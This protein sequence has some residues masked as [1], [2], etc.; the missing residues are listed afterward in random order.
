M[1]SVER[2]N[3]KR[4]A[5]AQFRLGNCMLMVSEAGRGFAAMLASYYLYVEDADSSQQRAIAADAIE[6]SPVRDQP[7]GNRQAGVRDRRCNYWWVSQRLV[8]GDY[9]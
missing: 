1:R 6:I 9:Q 4:I 7:Y 8:E 5:N 2:W 3:G